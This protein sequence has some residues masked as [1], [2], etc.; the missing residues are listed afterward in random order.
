MAHTK[1]IGS[2]YSSLDGMPGYCRVTPLYVWLDFLTVGCWHPFIHLGRERQ[3][4]AKA[5]VLGNNT[6]AGTSL[7][8]TPIVNLSFKMRNLDRIN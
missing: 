4:G 5:L 6:M 7:K 1:R 3:Y 8:T 2:L